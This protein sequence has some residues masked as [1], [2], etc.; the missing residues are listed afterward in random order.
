MEI[1]R[2]RKKD[3]ADVVDMIHNMRTKVQDKLY[4]PKIGVIGFCKN[5]YQKNPFDFF[6]DDPK[7]IKEAEDIISARESIE[8]NYLGK[9][10]IP[11]KVIFEF[12]IRAKQFNM[13]KDDF[14]VAGENLVEKVNNS[15]YV[16]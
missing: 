10:D 16:K 4:I 13:A 14:D 8:G 15:Q 3:H 7:I 1:Y 12:I 5:T 11:E 9:I 2:Y 6:S